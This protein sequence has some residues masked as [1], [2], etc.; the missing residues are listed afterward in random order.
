MKNISFDQYYRNIYQERWDRLKQSLLADKHYLKIHNVFQSSLPTNSYLYPDISVCEDEI[1]DIKFGYKLDGASIFPPRLF[2]SLKGKKV[3]DACASPGGKSISLLNR[4]EEIEYLQLNE[5]S[6]NRFFRLK[7]NI[8]DYIGNEN[9]KVNFSRLNSEKLSVQLKDDFD[10]ILL[11][12]PCSS[13]R[14]VL[15][16]EKEIEIW[17]PKRSKVLAKRQW[18][19]ITNCFEKLKPGGELIYSTCSIS[20]LEN[21]EILEKFTKK[22]QGMFSI[23]KHNH[24]F[25]SLG[26]GEE[27]EYGRIFLPDTCKY[28]PL[29]IAHIK[30][31]TS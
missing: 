19:M 10:L 6:K 5:L 28:G 21:D 23:I 4:I 3:L 15:N 17:S 31:M 14:H 18:A 8:E 1:V 7:K 20:P 2:T 11:D 12:A 26:L 9:H 16:D 29:Y 24:Y 22:R 27:T 30:K 13:E 25:D